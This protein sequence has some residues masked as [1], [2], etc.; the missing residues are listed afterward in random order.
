MNQESDVL[1]T[2]EELERDEIDDL[3]DIQ[4]RRE[5]SGY[6][7]NINQPVCI[8]CHGDAHS[9]PIT[10]QMRRMRTLFQRTIQYYEDGPR[11]SDELIAQLDA[12]RYDQD[13]SE[14]VCPGSEFIGA[15][16]PPSWILERNRRAAERER[17]IADYLS[18][19]PSFE[20]L[21]PVVE[22]GHFFGSLETLGCF[23]AGLPLP[24]PEQDESEWV[25]VPFGPFARTALGATFR[26]VNAAFR[27]MAELVQ[28]TLG[29]GA[30]STA[31]EFPAELQFPRGWNLVQVAEPRWWRLVDSDP[32]V[33]VEINVER[34]TSDD[35]LGLTPRT[36]LVSER[37]TLSIRHR[38]TGQ[39]ESHE[40][41]TD[42]ER[43]Y[44]TVRRLEEGRMAIEVFLRDRP[45]IGEWV[46][47]ESEE[48]PAAERNRRQRRGRRESRDPMWVNP[49]R[50]RGRRRQA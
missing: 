31:W 48:A 16:R 47:V 4:L 12:Y 33:I 1:A 10:E 37:H 2:I 40:M 45:I 34:D 32:D 46:P 25:T 23:Y 13:D 8:H 15:P 18:G 20:R 7:H 44:R 19:D 35:W 26:G 3:V 28:S 11:A 50:R 36:M 17:Q 43:G 42:R 21:R 6:D 27:E 41:L 22:S 9:V 49:L 30:F 14:I 39:R 29:P 5:P 24:E 38:R